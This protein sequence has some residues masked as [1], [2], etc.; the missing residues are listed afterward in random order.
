MFAVLLMSAH[1]ANIVSLT[2]VGRLAVAQQLFDRHVFLFALPV[3]LSVFKV[4]VGLRQVENG[5]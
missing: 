3:S 4:S 5:A 2:I 1:Y